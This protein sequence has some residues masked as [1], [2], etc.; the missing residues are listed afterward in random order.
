LHKSKNNGIK[1]SALTVSEFEQN[2]ILPEYT[3]NPEGVEES[4]EERSPIF[5]SFQ[6]LKE[7]KRS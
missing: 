1:T 4:Q 6:H 2:S 5:D 7:K 3:D